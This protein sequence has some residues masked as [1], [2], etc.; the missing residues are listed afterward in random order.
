MVPPDDVAILF[1][2]FGNFGDS[3]GFLVVNGLVEEGEGVLYFWVREQLQRRRVWTW[4][5]S[6]AGGFYS[7]G[8]ASL[9]SFSMSMFKKYS[10]P[11]QFHSINQTSPFQYCHPKKSQSRTFFQCDPKSQ[12]Q[13]SPLRTWRVDNSRRGV[14]AGK[15]GINSKFIISDVRLG[16]IAKFIAHRLAVGDGERH[17]ELEQKIARGNTIFHR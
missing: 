16:A 12:S 11:I 13:G 7:L 3:P 15:V 2:V 1:D 6:L 10:N 5:S 4:F 8:G 17:P 9:L 14:S